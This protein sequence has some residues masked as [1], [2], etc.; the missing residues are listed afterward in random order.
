MDAL[1]LVALRC[2]GGVRHG[3]AAARGVKMRHRAHG[4]GVGAA[5]RRAA[6]AAHHAGVGAGQVR[7]ALHQGRVE[8]E[9]NLLVSWR[10]LHR[11]RWLPA[12]LAPRRRRRRPPPGPSPARQSMSGACVPLESE[13]AWLRGVAVRGVASP[14]GAHVHGPASEQRG[15]G[16]QCL[17]STGSQI[18][19]AFVWV[20]GVPTP[21][22]SGGAASWYRRGA[23]AASCCPCMH[24]SHRVHRRQ[25]LLGCRAAGRLAPP[26]QRPEEVPSRGGAGGAGRAGAGAGGVQRMLARC[27]A[28]LC[29]SPIGAP[30]HPPPPTGAE[31]TRVPRLRATR[32]RQRRPCG[33]A[34]R[35][36]G[37]GCRRPISRMRTELS[38]ALLPCVSG[39]WA[40]QDGHAVWAPP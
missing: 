15:C 11:P 40:Q 31:H 35:R 12:A 36:R 26:L 38:P 14:A 16:M 6:A 13:A 24:L 3:T 37:A 19:R 2:A 28:V 10:H 18:M 4:A 23:G 7:R 27:G 5:A 29:W 39:R 33:G 9:G 1:R 32:R 22:L 20:G 17:T 8:R 30:P 34:G 25:A 21:W